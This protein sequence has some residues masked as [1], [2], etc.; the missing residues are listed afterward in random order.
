MGYKYKAICLTLN[1]KCNELVSDFITFYHIYN[2]T[3]SGILK[4]LEQ[5]SLLWCNFVNY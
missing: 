2:R 5:S 4:I 3:L 1:A